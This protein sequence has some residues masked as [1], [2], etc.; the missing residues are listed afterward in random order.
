MSSIELRKNP[1]RQTIVAPEAC[2]EYGNLGLLLQTTL[3]PQKIIELFFKSIQTDFQLQGLIYEHRRHETPLRYTYGPCIEARPQYPVPAY[4]LPC[5]D[6]GV[7]IFYRHQPFSSTEETHLKTLIQTLIQPLKNG[8]L[9]LKVVQQTRVD[10]LT[11]LNNRLALTQ[12]F[13]H[14]FNRAIRYQTPLSILF[15]DLDFFKKINDQHGHLTGDYVLSELAFVLQKLLRSSDRAYRYGG[16]EFVIILENTPQKGAIHLA[17]RLKT[18]IGAYTFR[19]PNHQQDPFHVTVSIG[20]S[21]RTPEDTA[22]SLLNRADQ[23]LYEAKKQGRNR[24][25]L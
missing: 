15:L 25:I 19:Y 8:L 10:P 22:E 1:P 21:E 24:I 7:L 6:L 13:Q 11:G 3:E 5:D 18:G 17:N 14:Q 16:E 12:D 4:T 20:I 2:A 23:A 9:Y